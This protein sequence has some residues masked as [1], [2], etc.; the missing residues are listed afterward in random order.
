MIYWTQDENEYNCFAVA[1]ADLE[2]DQNFVSLIMHRRWTHVFCNVPEIAPLSSKSSHQ[3]DS[4]QYH[5]ES[6]AQS[7]KKVGGCRFYSRGG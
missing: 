2:S 6:F 3:D 5:F 1:A 7:P 4:T